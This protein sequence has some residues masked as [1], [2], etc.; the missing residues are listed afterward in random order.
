MPATAL[1]PRHQSA[2]SSESGEHATVRPKTLARKP[3]LA[4][5]TPRLLEMERRAADVFD[6]FLRERNVS[7]DA[8][9]EHLMCDERIVRDLRVRE[10]PLRL[11]H[12][13]GLPKRMRLR[14]IDMLRE[15]AESDDPAVN[16]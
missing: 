2:K 5:R 4:D 14:L 16:S 7:N 15:V 8:V 3:T 12:I 9:S 1:P 6:Q 11:I 13:L 10:R